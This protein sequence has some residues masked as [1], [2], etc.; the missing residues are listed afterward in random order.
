M[1]LNS[2]TLT[3]NILFINNQ[4]YNLTLQACLALRAFTR[5]YDLIVTKIDN[6]QSQGVCYGIDEPLDFNSRK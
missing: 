4:I 1:L 2:F 3:M 5:C 6:L